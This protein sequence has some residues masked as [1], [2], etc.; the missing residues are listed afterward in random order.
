MFKV[1]KRRHMWAVEY[2]VS[3]TVLVLLRT[4]EDALEFALMMVGLGKGKL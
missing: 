2:G 1:R 4:H 3:R